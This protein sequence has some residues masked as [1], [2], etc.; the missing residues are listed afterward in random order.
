MPPRLPATSRRGN[1]P[2]WR[3]ALAPAAA[4]AGLQPKDGSLPL[5]E[6]SKP[7]YLRVRL[8]STPTNHRAPPA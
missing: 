6:L 2:I 4:L 8:L 7:A 3:E 1:L 5:S